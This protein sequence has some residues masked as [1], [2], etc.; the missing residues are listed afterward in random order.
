[1]LKVYTE[2]QI[3]DQDKKDSGSLLFGLQ[4][5]NTYKPLA[6]YVSGDDSAITRFEII[7]FDQFRKEISRESLSTSLIIVDLVNHIYNVDG[8]IL[9]TDKLSNGIYRFEFENVSEV[10]YK[11]EY[12][13]VE[14]KKVL[15]RFS[16]NKI[17]WST[18]IIKFSDISTI[19]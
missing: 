6:F 1:M 16:T 17:T 12:F 7:G 13:L 15:I 10:K 19:I 5:A 18:N 9:Y 8:S 3:A 11:T 4:G 2:D 14:E